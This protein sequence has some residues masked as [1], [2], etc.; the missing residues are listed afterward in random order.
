MGRYFSLF[1]IPYSLLIATT[2]TTTTTLGG[3]KPDG[4]TITVNLST[5]V[6][7]AVGVSGSSH[8]WVPISQYIDIT[9]GV[10]GDI[11]TAPADGYTLNVSLP[12]PMHTYSEL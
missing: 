7:S 9:Y 2:T 8:D 4:T 10:S 1:P 11:Y 6:A 5:G 3:I 12:T